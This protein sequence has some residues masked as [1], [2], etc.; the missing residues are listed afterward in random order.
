MKPRPFKLT[1]KYL[2]ERQEQIGL[3]RWARLRAIK[4]P[5]LD[6]LIAVPNGGYALDPATGAKLKAEGLAKGFPD[7]ILL[8]A[9]GRYHGLAI[10]LKSQRKGAA[11]RPEQ[12]QWIERLRTAG[13]AVC[14][15]HGASAAIKAIEKYLNLEAIGEGLKL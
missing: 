13:Y 12:R 5:A 3:V 6:M 8:C 9:R 4:E 2:T 7:M 14:V 10:E 15:A 11:L 1:A